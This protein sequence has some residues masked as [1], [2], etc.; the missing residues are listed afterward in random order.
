MHCFSVIIFGKTSRKNWED[1][2]NW[3]IYQS[4]IYEMPEKSADCLFTPKIIRLRS[5][6]T[7]NP[8]KLHIP[9]GGTRK[10]WAFC[11]IKVSSNYYLIV[12]HEFPFVTLTNS[13]S[14]VVSIESVLIELPHLHSY[15]IKQLITWLLPI[16]GSKW[17]LQMLRSLC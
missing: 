16:I 13:I 17:P 4:F 9:I 1:I 5:Y 2:C 12:A 7:K 11:I 6:T 15:Y 8:S 3:S 14:T 10:C